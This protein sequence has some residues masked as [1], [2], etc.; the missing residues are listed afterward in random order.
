MQILHC[1]GDGHLPTPGPFP[2]FQT[3]T[4]FPIRIKIK[5][6]RTLKGLKWNY[7]TVRSIKNVALLTEN[8]AFALLF[9]PHPGG[10]DSSKV[11]TP[12]N[13]PSKAQKM[14]MPGGQPGRGGEAGRRWN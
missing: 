13:L 10:F 2:N 8:G 11:P 1:P 12:G 4:R 7:S 9:R 5:K 6:N 3:R 14:P